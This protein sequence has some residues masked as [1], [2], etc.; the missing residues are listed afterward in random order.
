MHAICCSVVQLHCIDRDVRIFWDPTARRDFLGLEA[1]SI[2]RC[3]HFARHE[4][5]VSKGHVP[6]SMVVVVLL[7]VLLLPLLYC[8]VT[9]WL[10]HHNGAAADA[11]TMVLLIMPG[12]TWCSR[13]Q[14]ADCRPAPWAVKEA[15]MC[16]CV[17]VCRAVCGQ[18]V[19]RAGG[20]IALCMTHVV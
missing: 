4:S 11:I 18:S 19:C 7:V 10:A 16:G 13:S 1:I 8:C 12:C 6:A 2:S 9:S 5:S 17:V 3:L 14:V 20:C 15:S